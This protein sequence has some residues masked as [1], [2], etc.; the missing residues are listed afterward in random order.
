MQLREIMTTNFHVIPHNA[1]IQQA[2]KMMRDHD[3]GLLPVTD[4]DKM[5]GTVT[6]RDVVV[7]IIANGGDTSSIPVSQAMTAHLIYT[8]E[9]RDVNEAISIMQEKQVRRLI[10]VNQAEQ[11][12]GLVSLSDIT[13]A[14][15]ADEMV[16]E[17]LHELADKPTQ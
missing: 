2:A 14:D 16:A 13:R 12:V 15:S 4:N 5:I 6:D 3:I 8:Y 11:V 17:M 7:R 9:D 10:V 1:T